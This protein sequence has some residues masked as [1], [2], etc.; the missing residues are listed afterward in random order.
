VRWASCGEQVRR[1][2]PGLCG[3]GLRKGETLAVVGSC[4]TEWDLLK[5]KR[6]EVTER[7]RGRLEALCRG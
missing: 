1:P 5:L 2:A 6:N 7:F 3:L 4:R